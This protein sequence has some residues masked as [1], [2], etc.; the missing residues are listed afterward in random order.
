MAFSWLTALK[1]VPWDT[2]LAHAPGVL[3]KARGF[4]DKHRAG[5]SQ[6]SS[7]L[8][9]LMQAQQQMAQSLSELAE[10]NAALIAAVTRLQARQRWLA[11]GLGLTW[12]GCAV[13]AWWA[14]KPLNLV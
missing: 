10:Q 6:A 1:A 2:V 11:T 14:D 12:V 3:E 7:E 13:L 4:I 8:D 9:Q 5:A